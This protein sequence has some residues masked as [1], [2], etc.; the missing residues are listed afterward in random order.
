M[1]TEELALYEVAFLLGKTV[2]ELR[3]DIPFRELQGWFDYLERRPAGWRED[4]RT[5]MLLGA[6]G[7]KEKPE[8]LFPSLA[9]LRKSDELRLRGSAMH[10]FIMQ[11]KGGDTLPFLR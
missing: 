6:Q 10:H 7:V 1:S 11:A 2:T 3:E 9:E 8:R 5:A 4:Q